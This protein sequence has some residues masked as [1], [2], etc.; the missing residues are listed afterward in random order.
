MRFSY[1]EAMTTHV[2]TIPL[3]KRSRR[4]IQQHDDFDSIAHSLR[5][6]LEVPGRQFRR[7]FIDGKPF[8]E[9]CPDSSIGR[10]MTR[11][12]FNLFRPRPSARR[13]LVAALGSQPP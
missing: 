3:A 10:S 2:S 11:L 12:Q 8:I 13:P 5:I 1:A 7:E 9:T 6:R 4:A